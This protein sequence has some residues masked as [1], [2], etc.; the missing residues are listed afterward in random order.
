MDEYPTPKTIHKRTPRHIQLGI[1]LVL[2]LAAALRFYRLAGQSLWSD[3]GN[4]ISLA[5]ASLAE[6]ASRTALDIHP[7]LYYWL[8]HIWMRL[9][10]DSEIAVRALSVLCSLLLVAVIYRLGKCLFGPRAALLAAFIAAIS[11]FQI[12]YA[13][14]TRMYA[15]LALMGGLA[16]LA[17]AE[18]FRTMEDAAQPKWSSGKW[19]LLYVTAGALGLYTHYAFPVVLAAAGVAGLLAVWRSTQQKRSRHLLIWIGL[20]L[21]P[22]ILYLPWLPTAW[23][24]L[25]TWPAPGAQASTSDAVIT[26][27][28]TLTLGPTAQGENF[29][30]LLLALVALAG[31][32][33]LV[34]YPRPSTKALILLYMGLP[35]GLT[36]LLFK[37]AYLKFLLVAAPAYALL[38]ALPVEVVSTGASTFRRFA[39][40]AAALSIVIL[41]T[42][43]VWQS[44]HA[45]YTDP[46]AARDDYRR[47][48][49]YLTVS[50][51]PEDAILLN[52]PGQAEV[53]GYYYA[54]PTP[55]YP[56]PQQRP[57]D[58]DATLSELEGIVAASPSIY[59][60][61][62]A[63]EESDPQG[64][65]EGWLKAHT[66]KASDIWFGNVRLVTYAAPLPS[67]QMEVVGVIFADAIELNS[68]GIALPDSSEG[69][70]PALPGDIVQVNLQW[71]AWQQV[72]ANYVVFIQI[73][74]AANHIVGQRDAAPASPTTAWAPGEKILD[75]HGVLILPGTPP[76]E[77]R[78]IMGL[79]D[80]TS[81]ERLSVKRDPAAADA[82][83]IM[84]GKLTI[85]RPSASLPIEAFTFRHAVKEQIGPFH[86]HGYDQHQLGHSNEPDAALAPGTPVHLTLIWQTLEKPAADWQV[87]LTLKRRGDDT[88]LSQGS[89]PIAGIDYPSSS[90]QPEEIIRAQYDL[91]L[92][93]DL[94]PGSYTVNLTL[95][96]GAQVLPIDG[97]SL[98]PF[99]VN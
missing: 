94:T 72:E 97:L 52:A 13:Q 73:V 12:H 8:L 4:S 84:L 55:I 10:G 54:G 9:F 60:V 70:A 3:E 35:I 2:V 34:Q 51:S 98:Q 56:L 79:Y 29:W 69:K 91:W 30:T 28:R 23:R 78:L 42:A 25:T 41:T 20:N 49:E 39:S 71:Q 21:L 43:S 15:L 1:G 63:T 92:P 76:G 96:D 85:A 14:E 40:L 7:P 26:V 81:G 53:F 89:Y 82:D 74:D 90:W 5:Q 32:V 18:V 61:Y 24:Q 75:R 68:Y 64:L 88:P 45:Y 77:Y 66:F 48:A 80:Q 36:L 93:G 50:A 58:P 46:A 86:L 87:T 27:W 67:P 44:L 16:I 59:A 6:I 47:I 57:L 19:M 99:T 31:I 62:W 17:A 83:S 65:I 11:P 33:Q 22:I 38:L 37:P 95:T